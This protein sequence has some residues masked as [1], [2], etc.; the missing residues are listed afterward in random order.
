M[1]GHLDVIGI[2]VYQSSEIPIAKPGTEIQVD[3][4]TYIYIR[5]RTGGTVTTGYWYPYSISTAGIPTIVNSAG[6]GLRSA[7]YMGRTDPLGICVPQ[8]RNTTEEG[9]TTIPANYYFWGAVA[10]RFRG[11]AQPNCAQAV[12]IYTSIATGC[13]DDDPNA[14]DLVKGVALE[15]TITSGAYSNFHALRKMALNDS[16]PV[17][18]TGSLTVT[19]ATALFPVGTEVTVDGKLYR[20]ALATEAM[21][22]YEV[23][24]EVTAGMQRATTARIDITPWLVGVPQQA[25]TINHYG[26]FQRTGAMTALVA[27]NCIAS[28]PVYST[29]TVGVVDDAV[30][31]LIKGLRNSALV[32]GVQAASPCVAVVPLFVN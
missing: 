26:W 32:G 17:V 14:Q 28:S 12:P 21:T 23:C 24:I 15:A 9:V 2:D 3:D 25:M 30:T 22:G 6:S 16:S 5:N 13:V 4:T 27:A 1:A 31:T 20:Y 29:A 7:S 19:S 10:G 8:A 18:N 11:Y